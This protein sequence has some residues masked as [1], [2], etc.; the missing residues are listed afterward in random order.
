MCYL[1]EGLD[2]K[3]RVYGSAVLK[4]TINGPNSAKGWKDG[5]CTIEFHDGVKYR[6]NFPLM[7]IANLLSGTTNQYF[8]GHSEIVDMTNNLVADM[9]YNPWSDNTYSG[10]VKRA[11]PSWGGLASKLKGKSKKTDG[12]RPKRADDVHISIFMR[13][14][15]D[16][17]KSKKKED[18]VILL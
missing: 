13:S 2:K 4:G 10:M 18:K 6:V 14:D 8:I 3:Y 9:H 1:L 7:I 5:K 16:Q 12:E 11:M 15:N 17:Q